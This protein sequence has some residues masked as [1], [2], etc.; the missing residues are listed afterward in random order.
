M[1]NQKLMTPLDYVA[2]LLG[3]PPPPR[4]PDVQVQ[5]VPTPVYMPNPRTIDES[6]LDFGGGFGGPQVPPPIAP[7]APPGYGGY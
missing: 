6:M 2:F 5:P 4:E 7:Q 3:A 1:A